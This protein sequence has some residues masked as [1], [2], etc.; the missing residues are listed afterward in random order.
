MLKARERLEI[1]SC[2]QGKNKCGGSSGQL[3]AEHIPAECIYKVL[4]R[5]CL[6]ISIRIIIFYKVFTF[7]SHTKKM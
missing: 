3:E 1:I 6:K 2:R 4:D 5:S 7:K